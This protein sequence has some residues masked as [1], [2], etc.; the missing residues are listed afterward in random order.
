MDTANDLRQLGYWVA[1]ILEIRASDEYHVYL[2]IYWMYSPDDLPRDTIHANNLVGERQY[3][4][5]ENEIVA[6]NHSKL[7][8]VSTAEYHSTHS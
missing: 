8:P 4:Y 7:G 1:K 6:S 2:R 5:S 3:L